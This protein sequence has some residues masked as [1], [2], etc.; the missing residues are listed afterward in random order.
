MFAAYKGHTATINAIL[1]H[2]EVDVNVQ[3]KV[4][5]YLRWIL[6]VLLFCSIVSNYSA[7]SIYTVISRF[8]LCLIVSNSLLHLYFT[9]RTAGRR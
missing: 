1:L 8:H 9:S 3:N 7:H 4:S 2:P 6:S 5:N